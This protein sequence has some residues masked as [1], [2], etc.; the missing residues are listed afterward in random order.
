MRDMTPIGLVLFSALQVPGQAYMT[1]IQLGITLA[2]DIGPRRVED[3]ALGGLCPQS[4]PGHTLPHVPA[5]YP[6]GSL[7]MAGGLGT[8]QLQWAH[9]QSCPTGDTWGKASCPCISR[10]QDRLSSPHTEAQHAF[11]HLTGSTY[12]RSPASP[13]APSP[14]RAGTEARVASL[15]QP[16]LPCTLLTPFCGMR[17][18]I[19]CSL[20][21]SAGPDVGW[22]EGGQ[23]ITWPWSLP[24]QLSKVLLQRDSSLL[25]VVGG[26]YF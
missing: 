7:T 13:R 5:S 4:L 26:E 18:N 9:G 24:M 12:R 3:M 16:A 21:P 20:I 23:P 14:G 15:P 22:P 25:S 10:R 17:E 11:Q 6:S 1:G 19:P 2:K 8:P